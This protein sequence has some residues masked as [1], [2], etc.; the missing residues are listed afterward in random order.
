MPGGKHLA[1]IIA[2]LEFIIEN[3]SET[4]H[5]EM[6]NVFL[7]YRDDIFSCCLWVENRKQMGVFQG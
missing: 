1:L 3:T 2:G 5:E 4:K 7:N 6:L